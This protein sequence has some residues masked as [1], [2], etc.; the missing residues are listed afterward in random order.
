MDHTLDRWVLF[1]SKNVK[2]RGTHGQYTVTKN[3]GEPAHHMVYG[4]I[5]D[6]VYS[7]W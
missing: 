1:S 2:R 4:P 7:R 5:I 6:Q 3:N